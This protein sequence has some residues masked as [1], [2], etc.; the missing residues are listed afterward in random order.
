MSSLKNQ[1]IEHLASELGRTLTMQ[2]KTVTTAESCTGGGIAY[3]ITEVAGSSA[4]FER[5]WVTYAN[6]AK[7]QELGI[8]LKIIDEHGAVSEQ[9]VQHMALGA[10]AKSGANISVAVSGIAGPTGGTKAKPL[11]LVWFAIADDEGVHSFSR[12][13]SGN[14]QQIR[15]QTIKLSLQELVERL[16]S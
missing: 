5:S 2:N 12:C 6:L 3:A 9:V 7:S 11:G 14:R 4:W 15:E 10:F 8:D 16:V 13:F 1:S